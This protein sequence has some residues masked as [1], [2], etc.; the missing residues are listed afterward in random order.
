MISHTPHLA[1]TMYVRNRI[2]QWNCR[3]LRANTAELGERLRT[4]VTLPVAILLQETRGTSPGIAGYQGY[5]QPSIIHEGTTDPTAQAAIF[6]QRNIRRCQLDT[7]AYCSDTQEVVAV[8]ID[9]N[10]PQKIILVSA[11]LRPYTGR[12]RRGNFTWMSHLRSLFPSDGIL[13]AG[14]FNAANTT[15]GYRR[16]TPRG[17]E[18]EQQ[19]SLANLILLNDLDIP[20]RVALHSLQQCTTPDIAWSSQRLITSWHCEG[21][22]WSSDHYPIWL[23]LRTGQK[24]RKRKVH[25]TDWNRFREGT[26]SRIHKGDCLTL[27][28]AITSALT[29]STRELKLPEDVPAPY[30]HLLNLWETREQMH[31]Q[32]LSNGQKFKELIKLRHKTAQIRQQSKTLTRTRWT[33][34]CASFNSTT[35]LA[36][37]CTT[38]TALQGKSRTPNMVPTV[39]LQQNKSLEDIEEEAAR[40]FFPQPATSPRQLLYVPEKVDESNPIESLFTMAELVTALHQVRVK[41]APGKDGITWSAL[42]NLPQEGKTSLLEAI[43]NVLVSGTQTCY[44][45][46]NT[47]AWQT[48]QHHKPSQACVS[49]TYHL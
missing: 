18:L 24:K 17:V 48:A 28:D 7:S 36:K 4:M 12:Q 43:N 11:Y 26:A 10:S 27:T 1:T 13:V 42:R 39:A 34:H 22:L 32:Y 5:F 40:I 41:S 9:S 30:K 16:N 14:H 25:C 29:E 8:R 47:Q 33:E 49:H 2:L 46:S 19:A 20:S 15:W 44:G 37:L 3:S 35:G 31:E 6:I 21:D 45:H 38:F 23:T